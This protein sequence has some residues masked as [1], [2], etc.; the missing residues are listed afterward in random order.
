MSDLGATLAFTRDHR[1]TAMFSVYVDARLE[2]APAYLLN[3][4]LIGLWPAS[5]PRRIDAILDID[6][7]AD[8]DVLRPKP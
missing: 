8:L 1:H 6:T 3:Q 5:P 2:H 7:P 4:P